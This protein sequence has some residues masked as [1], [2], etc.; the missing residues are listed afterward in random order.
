M[1]MSDQAVLIFVVKFGK[2]HPDSVVETSALSSIPPP[3]ITYKLTLPDS[4]IE[5]GLLTSLQLEAV[6]Y[7][8]QKHL[9]FLPS[10]ER[11]GYLVGEI[12][13]VGENLE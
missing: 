10:G 6:I 4:I 11:A 12:S 9:V 13:V 3:D 5:H 2:P 7:A 1:I 8:C